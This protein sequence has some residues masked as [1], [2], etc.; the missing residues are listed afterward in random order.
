MDVVK[1]FAQPC[2]PC[3]GNRS[4]AAARTHGCSVLFSEELVVGAPYV[5]GV[6]KI[7]KVLAQSATLITVLAVGNSIAWIG[8]PVFGESACPS[9]ERDTCSCS[10]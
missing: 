2:E 7:C 6:P 4:L 8:L 10:P 9:S 1:A 5:A 3:A